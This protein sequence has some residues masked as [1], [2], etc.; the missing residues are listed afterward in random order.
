MHGI[1]ASSDEILITNGSQNGID[2]VLKMLSV[3]GKKIAIESP[4]YAI[5]LPLLK[6]YKIE[7]AAIPMK[8]LRQP[9]AAAMAAAISGVTKKPALPPIK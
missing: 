7:I 8:A 4:T 2:L 3:P 5:L 6:Y 1:S 9:Q